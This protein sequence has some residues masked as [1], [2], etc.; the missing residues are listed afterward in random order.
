MGT[1]PKRS[2]TSPENSPAGPDHE[3]LERGRNRG[4][5]TREQCRARVFSGVGSASQQLTARDKGSSVSPAL[6]TARRRR[7]SSK[8]ATGHDYRLRRGLYALA[9]PQPRPRR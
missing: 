6:A 1:S 5:G 4:P 9:R 3:R 8:G 2:K 7:A